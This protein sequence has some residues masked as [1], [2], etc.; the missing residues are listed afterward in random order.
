MV[1]YTYSNGYPQIQRLQGGILYPHGI[2][3]V[4]FEGENGPETQYRFKLLKFVDNSEDISDYDA[5]TATFRDQIDAQ[6]ADGVDVQRVTA[7]CKDWYKMKTAEKVLAHV[8][9][10]KGEPEQVAVRRL[11]LDKTN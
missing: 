9:L 8:R 3:Q 1:R 11:T 10:G 6:I 4:T 5:F 2:E 7:K